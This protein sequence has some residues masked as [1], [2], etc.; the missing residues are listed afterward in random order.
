MWTQT[1]AS[2]NT[3]M[4]VIADTIKINNSASTTAF[5]GDTFYSED[6]GNYLKLVE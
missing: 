2:A 4:Q 5:D 6:D 3:R 1:S